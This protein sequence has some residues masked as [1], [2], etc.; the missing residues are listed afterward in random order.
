VS[1]DSGLSCGVLKP[2]IYLGSELGNSI[3]P[4]VPWAQLGRNMTSR[5]ASR[6]ILE[7]NAGSDLD[8]RRPAMTI[9]LTSHFIVRKAE[10]LPR[11][12]PALAYRISARVV[13]K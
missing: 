7:P 9:V 5:L 13:R 2:H 11:R 12:I 4:L 8:R 6:N 3:R 10:I 1:A